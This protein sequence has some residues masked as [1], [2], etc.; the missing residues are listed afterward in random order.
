MTIH[1]QDGLRAM[2]VD[3]CAI[4]IYIEDIF[5]CE[6]TREEWKKINMAMEGVKNEDR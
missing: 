6:M 4:A 2:M 5:R 3:N 1:N